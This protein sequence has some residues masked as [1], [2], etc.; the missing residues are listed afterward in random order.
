M[1][2][3]TASRTSAATTPATTPATPAEETVLRTLRRGLAL[4]PELRL[5]LAGTTGLGL[6]AMAGRVAVPVAIQQAI[7]RGLRAAGGPD[8][9][10]VLTIVAGAL[11][12]LALT[13]SCQYLMMRRLF[14][15]SETAL[16]RVRTR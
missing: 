12:V 4:S 13:T 11:V 2:S 3:A 9:G 14:T 5:G 8:L 16:A 7:D 1:T 6:V 15:V 10:V